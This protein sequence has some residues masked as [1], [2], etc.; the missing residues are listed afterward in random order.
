MD[1]RPNAIE[2]QVV[3][4]GYQ[5]LFPITNARIECKVADS[6]NDL[7]LTTLVWLGNRLL[8]IKVPAKISSEFA[9]GIRHRDAE[10]NFGRLVEATADDELRI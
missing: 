4:R 9:I 3:G 10:M 7:E 8:A 5:F 6:I 2:N 1:E